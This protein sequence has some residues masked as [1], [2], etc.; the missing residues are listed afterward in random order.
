[1]RG[2][3]RG[4]CAAP[5]LLACACAPVSTPEPA[6][7]TISAQD[8]GAVHFDVG[9]GKRTPYSIPARIG[10]GSAG[11]STRS[12][13]TPIDVQSFRLYVVPSNTGTVSPIT[14]GGPFPLNVSFGAAFPAE[15]Q[16]VFDNVPGD[17]STYY[18]AVSAYDGS[19]GTGTNITGSGQVKGSIQIN[20]A[21]LKDA[22]AS[23]AGGNS[24]Q[25]DG[26]I[27]IFSAPNHNVNPLHLAPLL[28]FM[29]LD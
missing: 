25:D 8:D 5:V 28:V 29:T 10:L 13:K 9:G 2:I 14:N 1:M 18:I 11:F 12:L 23:I 22:F 24:V 27:Q 3:L 26:G 15:R 17:G 21:G 6:I 19:N 20:D 16:V 4:I 7:V